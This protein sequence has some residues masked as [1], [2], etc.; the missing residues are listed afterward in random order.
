MK[1]LLTC[2]FELQQ[3]LQIFENLRH[4]T[5]VPIITAHLELKALGK[6]LNH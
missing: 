6:D 3:N 5:V 1:T 4:R 2:L